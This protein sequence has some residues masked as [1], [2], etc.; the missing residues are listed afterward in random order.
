MGEEAHLCK[1]VPALAKVAEIWLACQHAGEPPR[2]S[3]LSSDGYLY[4]LLS[5]Q[6]D[7]SAETNAT[8][9]TPG[10]LLPGGRHCHRRLCDSADDED[11][12]L[13]LHLE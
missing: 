4:R 3:S 12:R 2:A 5:R 1:S 9:P 8:L 13:L 10:R 11:V 6:G 7:Y